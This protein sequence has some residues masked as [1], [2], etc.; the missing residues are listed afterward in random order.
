MQTTQSLGA[1]LR[2]CSHWVMGSKILVSSIPSYLGNFSSLLSAGF[3]ELW[4][5]GAH[6]DLWF[7]LS[8]H[9]ITS[10]VSLILSYLLLEE[11]LWWGQGTIYEDSRISLRVITS[12]LSFMWLLKIRTQI[13]MLMWQTLNQQTSLQTLCKFFW[14]PY[15]AQVGSSTPGFLHKQ[16]S[17]CR[18]VKKL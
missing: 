16:Q 2:P 3:P 17:K 13:L 1:H 15:L 18:E 14:D 5:K 10:W 4:G 8:L 11:S 7:R 12:V 9:I 6:E